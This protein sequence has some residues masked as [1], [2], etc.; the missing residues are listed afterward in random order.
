MTDSEEKLESEESEPTAVDAAN[1]AADSDTSEHDSLAETNT[2]HASGEAAENPED[3]VIE[4]DALA[5]DDFDDD[6]EDDDADGD[7]IEDIADEPE[8]VTEKQWVHLESP[9]E[10]RKFNL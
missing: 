9:S 8:E 1:A 4:D 7:P 2:D 6:F 10:S 3:S 5:E